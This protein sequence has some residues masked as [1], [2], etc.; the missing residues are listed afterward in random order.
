[1]RFYGLTHSLVCLLLFVS[2]CF[3]QTDSLSIDTLPTKVS[4]KKG[5]LAINSSAPA[6][7]WVN[8]VAYGTTPF[9]AEL[10]SGWVTISLRAQD[11]WT[12]VVLAHIDSGRTVSYNLPLKHYA[13]IPNAP[14]IGDVSKIHD[15][16]TL[17]NIYDKLAK[18]RPTAVGDSLCI[19]KFV[20]ESPLPYAAPAPLTEKSP[21]YQNYYAIYNIERQTDFND[22]LWTC[23]SSVESAQNKVL[24]RLAELSKSQVSGYVPVSAASFKQ[25]APDGLKGDLELSFRSPDGRADVLWKGKWES[26]D[27]KGDDLVRALT[28]A[29]PLALAFLS[30]GNQTVWIPVKAGL[31]EG[32]A[33]NTSPS[34]MK[35]EQTG[36]NLYY[37][38]FY[39]YSALNVSWNGLVF[40][41]KGE[42]VLPEYIRTQP[43]VA[44]WLGVKDTV[45]VADTVA[46]LP[47]ERLALAKIPAG[48]FNY[49][50]KKTEVNA[51]SINTT[52]ISQTL[53]KAECGK[54]KDFG[55]FVGDSLPAHS[56][57]WKE[58]SE[59]CVALGGNLPTE[60]QWEYA[61]RAGMNGKTITAAG[62]VIGDYAIYKSDIHKG[63]EKVGTKKP[64]GW[65]LYDVFGN[66]GEWVKDDGFWFGKYK[67]IKGG[68]WKSKE[69]D[70]SFENRDEEDARYWGTH[71]GFRCV[72]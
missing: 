15:L 22:Y 67:Y 63:I 41:L 8:G 34:V 28:S 66:V 17:E 47:I 71:L 20:E 56:V 68:S 29:Q 61:A 25:S 31:S 6:G 16:R 2:L 45:I 23:T 40:S 58:A 46:K 44:A 11:F 10:P 59:C 70:M 54:A 60:V 42:F 43:E 51:F 7:V 4:N 19:A 52:E 36:G 53:Y 72:F 57:N 5:V 64:N 39:K 38:H 33:N 30:V 50:G 24:L 21:E 3:S 69:K 49:K 65:G 13:E 27:F 12:S 55:D 62:S 18:I 32:G 48:S 26:S 37:R 1:M 9:S 35:A 14:E